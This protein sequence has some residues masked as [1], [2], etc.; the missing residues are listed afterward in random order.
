MDPGR[1]DLQPFVQALRKFPHYMAIPINDRRPPRGAGGYEHGNTWVEW[2]QTATIGLICI[3]ISF[4]PSPLRIDTFAGFETRPCPGESTTSSP[5]MV[6][7]E[8]LHVIPLFDLYR[9]RRNA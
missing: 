5:S 3:P 6:T 7:A 2:T 4:V 1:Q 9:A 8:D